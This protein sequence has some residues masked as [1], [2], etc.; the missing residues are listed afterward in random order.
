MNLRPQR[1]QYDYNRSS[2]LTTATVNFMSQVYFW[3]MIA[4][5][6]SGA[7]A[8]VVASDPQRVVNLVQNPWL[9]YGV[10]ILQL[11]AVIVLSVAIQRMSYMLTASLYLGY[12]VLTGIT[13]STIFLIYSMGS[14]AQAFFIT[15]MISGKSISALL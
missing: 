7:V 8:Y 13:F 3:M 2:A 1:D 11:A 4:L 9:F 15:S 14:I 12:S 5:A 6:I 10:I